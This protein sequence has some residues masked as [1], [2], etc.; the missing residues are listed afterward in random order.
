[1][2]RASRL[3]ALA[4]AADGEAGKEGTAPWFDWM[5]VKA[6]R[7]LAT[8][9]TS[10]SVYDLAAQYIPPKS[11]LALTLFTLTMETIFIAV[12]NVR[13]TLHDHRSGRNYFVADMG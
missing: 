13:T 6:A 9:S 12:F 5:Q 11:R 2:D 8:A 10:A 4:E 3:R 1:M 7:L